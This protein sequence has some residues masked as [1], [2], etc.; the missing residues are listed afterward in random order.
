MDGITYILHDQ[1]DSWNSNE[2]DTRKL[3]SRDGSACS[4]T[5]KAIHLDAPLAA[6]ARRSLPV[7]CYPPVCTRARRE[8]PRYFPAAHVGITQLAPIAI[9]MKLFPPFD[10]LCSRGEVSRNAKVDHNRLCRVSR[11]YLRVRLFNTHAM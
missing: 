11:E 3:R 6:C 8:L 7:P 5:C 10:G 4:P 9:F 2:R 1:S